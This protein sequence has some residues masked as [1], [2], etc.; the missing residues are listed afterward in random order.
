MTG[1]IQTMH[2]WAR[3]CNTLMHT[4][5]F[6]HLHTRSEVPA[7]LTRDRPQRQLS[8]PQPCNQLNPDI[9]RSGSRLP[10]GRGTCRGQRAHCR[11]AGLQPRSPVPGAR[12]H[13][14]WVHRCANRRC[15]QTRRDLTGPSPMCSGPPPWESTPGQSK[16]HPPCRGSRSRRW[17]GTILSLGANI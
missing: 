13:S 5:T 7:F 11:R 17:S 15:S 1:H 14:H 9:T 12:V 4:R 16:V 2:A 3:A 6:T 8:N 10:R